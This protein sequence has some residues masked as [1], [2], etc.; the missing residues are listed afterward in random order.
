[1]T[2]FECFCDLIEGHV[3]RAGIY[4]DYFV[5]EVST[6]LNDIDPLMNSETIIRLLQIKGFR[7]VDCEYL[8]PSA[9]RNR[10]IVR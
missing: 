9:D 2:A 7:V 4:V 5:A 1:M 6:D 10:H 8:T 3:E